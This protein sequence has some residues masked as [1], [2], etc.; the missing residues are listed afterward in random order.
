M[1]ITVAAVPPSVHIE[2]PTS[3][4][5]V[6]GTVT[7][8][9]WAIDNTARIGTAIASVQV[10]VDGST[11]G[12][13]T[14]GIMRSDVCTVYPGRPGCPNVGFTYALDTTK[15]SVGSHT[16]TVCATNSDSSPFTGCQGIPIT[17]AVALPSVH[18]E[19]PTKGSTVTGVITVKGW[20]IDSIST[21]GTA[22]A[23]VQVM[24]DGA[25]VG[26]ATYGLARPDACATYPGRPG[27]P[28]VGFTYSLDTS[29]LTSGSHTI[30]VTA[31]DS[32]GQP[33]AG[34]DSVSIIVP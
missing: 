8:K 15:L 21:V 29:N 23:A 2:R 32:D 30:T 3:G 10:Q 33:D 25:I 28:N 9:G 4:S 12:T 31:T 22:I 1:P 11:V 13:A 5:T 16:L 27:C 19:R 34:S 18:I 20:A 7:V 17:V 26:N 6:S 14:Y 24:V